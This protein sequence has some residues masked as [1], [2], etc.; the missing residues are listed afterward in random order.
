MRGKKKDKPIVG[1]TV[2]GFVSIL[3]LFYSLYVLL[4]GVTNPD[5]SNLY[6]LY[7]SLKVNL[8]LNSLVGLFIS[9]AMLIGLILTCLNHPN[10]EK[11]V[12]IIMHLSVI[13][14]LP[15]AIFTHISNTKIYGNIP[16]GSWAVYY[17][18]MFIVSAVSVGIYCLGL[19]WFRA[20]KKEFK[21]TSIAVSSAFILY[22]FIIIAVHPSSA[23]STSSPNITYRNNSNPKILPNVKAIKEP[24]VSYKDLS[25]LRTTTYDDIEAKVLLG[26]RGDDGFGS[27]HHSILKSWAQPE[28]KRR[29]NYLKIEPYTFS[30]GS[31]YFNF[32]DKITSIQLWM[33]KDT[34]KGIK[35]ALKIKY[36]NPQ[37]TNGIQVNTQDEN[38]RAMTGINDEY[39]WVD[40]DNKTRIFITHLKRAKLANGS[41]HT[42]PDERTAVLRYENYYNIEQQRLHESKA[43]SKIVDGL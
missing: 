22:F 27:Y 39:L 21:I 1:I 43:P 2:V 28:K 26:I 11:A 15:I 9:S 34:F 37:I 23:S 6:K 40:D 25:I 36:G 31:I 17:I 33:Y 13:L 19:Y 12:R 14:T 20:T 8:Y 32:E 18:T 7:P 5:A 29:E 38:G 16:S 3:S 41:W 4:N 35:S 42:P 10:G 24:I 30:R